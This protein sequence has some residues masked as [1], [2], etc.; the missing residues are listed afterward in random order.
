MLHEITMQ[1][2]ATTYLHMPSCLQEAAVKRDEYKKEFDA[3]LQRLRVLEAEAT[4]MKADPNREEQQYQ[5][6]TSEVKQLAAETDRAR[7]L[8][9]YWMYVASG[10]TPGVHTRVMTDSTIQSNVMHR[11]VHGS[12]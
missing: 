9:T 2:S 5:R 4:A 1:P 12:L 8:K 3:K 7:R 6:K 11:A 10:L